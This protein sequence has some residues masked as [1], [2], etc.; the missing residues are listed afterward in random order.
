[1]R[2]LI[3]RC[4][5]PWARFFAILALFITLGVIGK[6]HVPDLSASGP[7]ENVKLGAAASVT[8]DKSTTD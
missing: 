5:S 4:L 3:N 6:T 1:M 2:A 8:A 7:T